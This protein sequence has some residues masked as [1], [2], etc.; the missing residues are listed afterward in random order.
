LPVSDGPPDEEIEGEMFFVFSHK[1]Y[2]IPKPHGVNGSE[3][4]AAPFSK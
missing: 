4:R 1:T 2:G 3:V